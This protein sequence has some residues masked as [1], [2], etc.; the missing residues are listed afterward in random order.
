MALVDAHRRFIYVDIGC[1]GRVSDGGVWSRTNLSA[2]LMD[3][4]NPLNILPLKALPGHELKIPHFIVGNEAFPLKSYIMRPYPSRNLDTKKRIFNYRMR[5]ARMN[6]RNA[7]GILS[8]RF[9]IFKKSLN[10]APERVDL[11]VLTACCLHNLLLKDLDMKNT[12][13]EIMT[14]IIRDAPNA[15]SNN[16]MIIRNEIAEYCSSNG[17]VVE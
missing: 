1:N 5:R 4:N 13:L 9:R 6:V 11:F 15:S 7:F 12:E 10:N 14:E 2:L 3:E 17:S 8:S 16:A